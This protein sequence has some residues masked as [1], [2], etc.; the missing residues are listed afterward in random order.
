MLIPSRD[1]AFTPAVGRELPVC[2]ETTLGYVRQFDT[3]HNPPL[4]AKQGRPVQTFCPVMRR[5]V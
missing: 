3:V 5:F 4:F 1:I 2:S